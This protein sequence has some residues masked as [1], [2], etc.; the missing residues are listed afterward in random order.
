MAA[1]TEQEEA[2][3]DQQ[4]ERLNQRVRHLMKAWRNAY[5]VRHRT[6]LLPPCAL[7]TA[8]SHCAES[9]L[10]LPCTEAAAVRGIH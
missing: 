4:A 8:G 5:K 2:W 3:Y 7:V 9:G 10:A 1:K 6:R